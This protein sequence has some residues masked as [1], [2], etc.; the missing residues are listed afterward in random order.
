[1][2]AWVRKLVNYTSSSKGAK[3][4]LSVWLIAVVA[5]SIFAPG[6]KEYEVNSTEGSVNENTPSE[7]ADKV[8]D[9]EF[10]SDEGLTALIVFHDQNGLNES[11]IADITTF[12]E[13]LDSNEKPEGIANALPFHEVPEQVQEQMIS[14]DDSTLLFNIALEEDVSA[15]DSND[16]L[17]QLRDKWEIIGSPNIQFEVTGPAGISADTISLFQNADFVLMFATIILIFIILIFIYRS[18]LLAITPLLIAGIVY[19]VVD[20]VLGILG[21]YELF[22]IEGQAVSIMLVLLFAVVTDYSLFV[23]SRYRE[24]LRT[25]QSKYSAMNEAIYHVAEPIFFSGGTVTFAM[26]ALFA[27][28]F[29]PY[30]YFAPV[31]TIAVIHFNCGSNVNSCIICFARKKSILANDSKSK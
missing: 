18:P 9:E 19:G 13:W 24:E 28:V 2:L 6:S 22:S 23:F 10:P 7:I 25:H 8:L 15:S 11:G 31:F 20:R 27:T 26:L 17:Q 3:V 21:K 30:H 14:E 12:S 4:T 1:M 16:L 5:L 29:K